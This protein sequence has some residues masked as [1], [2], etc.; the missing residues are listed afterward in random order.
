ML[1]NTNKANFIFGLILA[2]CILPSIV[3]AA[4]EV[5]GSIP[6]V[7][8]LQPPAA[9]ISPN[10]SHNIQYVDTSREGDFDASG[11]V[12]SVS[13]QST[14]Q[15]ANPPVVPSSTGLF[16][17]LGPKASEWLWWILGILAVL[18]LVFWA[19]RHEKNQ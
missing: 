6:K 17:L 8:P 13:Q 3:Y 7:L 16:I 1:T 4:R 5:T 2:I 18:G 14:V 10:I 12:V 11:N 19:F 9:N 15:Q